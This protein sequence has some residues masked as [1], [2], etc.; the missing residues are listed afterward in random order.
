M[1]LKE[2]FHQI[3]VTVVYTGL[4]KSTI[5]CLFNLMVVIFLG[6]SKRTKFH[7]FFGPT[8]VS[9]LKQD[10]DYRQIAV[11]AKD[12]LNSCWLNWAQGTKTSGI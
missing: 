1:H 6:Q 8:N 2:I 5:S 3:T 7:H 4:G 12:P 11:S 9:G 10:E